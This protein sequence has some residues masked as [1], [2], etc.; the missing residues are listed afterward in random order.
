[1]STWRPRNGRVPIGSQ[2]RILTE[3]EYRKRRFDS[4]E[5]WSQRSHSLDF[6]VGGQELELLGRVLQKRQT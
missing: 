6:R 5:D 2:V 3:A 1:V 4:T